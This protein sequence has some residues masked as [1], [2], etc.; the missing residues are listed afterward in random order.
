[1]VLNERQLGPKHHAEDGSHVRNAPLAEA[2]PVEVELSAKNDPGDKPKI[3]SAY[4]SHLMD[5]YNDG[6]DKVGPVEASRI[7][8]GLSPGPS[9]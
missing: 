1:M 6:A 7:L 9:P 2:A 8:D 4:G 3:A 5:L